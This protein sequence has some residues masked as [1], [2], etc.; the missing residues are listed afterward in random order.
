MTNDEMTDGQQIREHIWDY[1]YGLL[2][3]E[4]SQEMV[5]RIKSDPQIARLYAEVRLKGELVAEAA[6]V[7]DS[8]LQLKATSADQSAVLSRE[9]TTTGTKTGALWRERALQLISIAAC[10]L[11]VIVGAGLCWPQPNARVLAQK[12]VVAD[13]VAPAS[14][15]AGLTNALA[16]HT[17]RV[18]PAGDATE[19][20]AAEVQ[21]RLVD[22]A[23]KEQFQKSLRTD[24]MGQV[25]VEIPGAALE[26]GSRLEVNPAPAN[27]N[28]LS[29]A[30]DLPVEPEP[31]IAYFL[32]AEPPA[33][34]AAVPLA[35]VRNSTWNFAAFSAKPIAQNQS[36]FGGLGGEIVARDAAQSRTGMAA[37]GYPSQT[38]RA[39]GR[40]RNQL[41]AS[42]QRKQ[43]GA[44]QPT[45]QVV[46]AGKP[47]QVEIPPELADRSLD[48]AVQCRGVTVAATSESQA[49]AKEGS[50]DEAKVADRKAKLASRQVT[51]A[52]P[53]EAD[54]LM[55]VEIYDQKSDQ[56]EPLQRNLVYR[57]PL[58]KLVVELPEFHK[59]VAAGDEIEMKIR[60][61]D[62]NGRPAANTRL[63]IRVW[64][65]R[66]VQQLGDRPLLLTDAVL[67]G[68]GFEY[69][70]NAVSTANQ[71]AQ[72]SDLGRLKQQANT[73]QRR[74]QAA[75][76]A[77][78]KNAAAETVPIAGAP[79]PNSQL[80]ETQQLARI[81]A[82]VGT[83]VELASNR[84]AVKLA[85]RNAADESS[86]R[87]ERAMKILGATAVLGGIAVLVIVAAVAAMKIA[88]SVRVFVVP[89]VTALGSL[90]IGAFWVGGP[91]DHRP[92][93]IALAA[94]TESESSQNSEISSAPA[95]AQLRA[96]L[97]RESQ[98]EPAGGPGPSAAAA[99]PPATATPNSY[100]FAPG[101]AVPR[102]DAAKPSEQGSLRL[103]VPAAAPGAPAGVAG[104]FGAR[105]A[106]AGPVPALANADT[107]KTAETEKKAA[108]KDANSTATP[109]SL[110]F[111]PNLTTDADGNATIRFKMPSVACEYRLLIDA[112]G[113]G[114]IGSRQELL[115][116]GAASK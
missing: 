57:Q 28:S 115:S 44:S 98:T 48:V 3:E 22:S 116:C 2:S 92:D 34:P 102:A 66:L 94:R 23:G 30:T 77:P 91:R 75:R 32:E 67:K 60:V 43:E 4:E 11:I 114:R 56:L 38:N 35:D 99:S 14:L 54:G 31:E 105:S 42:D 90:L 19:N 84:D 37:N 27:K 55:E 45:A 101:G 80:N 16:V 111:E 87:R 15:P 51:V 6:I 110:F 33:D 73:Y 63:G 59:Q 5:A 20:I 113:S 107:K 58:R 29:L 109:P 8:S 25:S 46:E 74:M 112:L 17:Y 72:Q 61:A 82:S 65:E 89:L 69:G 40:G 24:A 86:A 100:A 93:A 13:V 78:A 18:N 9:Q 39:G 71:V 36:Q 106:G 88:A 21:L 83:K 1:V 95:D 85:I 52:L 7:E 103:A 62:E 96:N 79:V 68:Q 70:Q 47:V 53:P 97:R 49:A 50:A 104:G 64:N 81:D 76:A 26:P 10:G 108:D 12:F 41:A